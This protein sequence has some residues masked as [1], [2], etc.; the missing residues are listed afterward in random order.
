MASARR[1]GPGL[2]HAMGKGGGCLCEDSQ[3]AAPQ[4]PTTHTLE[5]SPSLREDEALQQKRHCTDLLLLLL[6]LAY[7]G[8][9]LFVL[10][11]GAPTEKLRLL[12]VLAI[13]SQ[14][15]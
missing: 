7:W 2:P 14:T 15:G 6:F 1:P 4:K 11:A 5:Q 3:V 9:M 8:G 12:G 13:T 10:V